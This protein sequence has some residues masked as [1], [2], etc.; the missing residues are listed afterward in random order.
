MRRR[1]HS[2]ALRGGAGGVCVALRAAQPDARP[3]G[4]DA[5]RGGGAVAHLRHRHADDGGRAR[6]GGGRDV[7]DLDV[8]VAARA[9]VSLRRDDHRRAGDG[10]LHPAAA[11]RAPGDPRVP[12]RR[13]GSRGGAAG[14]AVRRARVVAALR[15]RELRARLRHRH[16][17]RAAVQGDQGQA[18]RLLLRAAAVAA[19]ARPHEP[20]RDRHRLDLPDHRA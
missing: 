9:L 8:R 3:L 17:L 10:R 14:A 15:L 16:H 11:R 4:D 20:A 5:A 13:R 19:G 7:G 18:P 2:R 12:A 6:A 1:R